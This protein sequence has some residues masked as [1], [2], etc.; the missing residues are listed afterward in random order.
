MARS[1]SDLF[2]EHQIALAN[3]AKSLSH[4]ARV[5]IV[6]L[7]Q[8]H[9]EASCGHIVEALPL[10]QP[11]VSQHLRA[12]LEAGLLNYRE[13]GPMVYYSLNTTQIKS[14]CHAFQTAMGTLEQPAPVPA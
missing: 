3:F 13:V 4:P 5:A 8:Q 7:L 10:A 12:M 2:S 11:T 14:F 9:G 1:K 6:T